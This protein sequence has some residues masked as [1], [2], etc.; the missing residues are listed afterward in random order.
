[1][2][3]AIAVLVYELR[4]HIE[5]S[6]GL[7]AAGA[8]RLMNQG[9]LLI[10]LRTK[11]AYDGGHIGE[12]RNIPFAEIEAQAETLKKWQEK[13]VITYCDSGRD[14][15]AAARKLA[16]L[17]F[18]KVASLNGGIGAWVRDNMP[19]AKSAGGKRGGG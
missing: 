7:S 6:A 19:L 9:A 17:G 13:P 15:A 16:K 11:D 14:G 2:F 10:D 18:T 12:A 8:V 1:V 4:D 5:G 3:V